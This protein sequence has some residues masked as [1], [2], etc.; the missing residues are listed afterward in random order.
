MIRISVSLRYNAALDLKKTISLLIFL[1]TCL[2][3]KTQYYSGSDIEFG[4]N[5]VQYNS[6]FWQS[7]DFERFK[8]YF[9]QSGRKH[10][11]YTAKTAHKHLQELEKFLDYETN[12]K[13]HFVVFNTQSEFRQSNI[14]LETNNITSNI[15]GTARIEGN[16]IFIYYEGDHIKLNNQI[17]T[18]LSQ[19]LVT[20]ILYGDNWKQSIKNASLLNVPE[21][22]S[23]G[24]VSYLGE[25]W[26][27]TTDNEVKNKI[28]SGRYDKFSHLTGEQ[29][30]LAGKTIWNYIDE[31]Y[32]PRMIPN[33]LYMT[34]V[35]KNI[36][37]GFIYVLGVNLSKLSDDFVN[38]YKKRYLSDI[39]GRIDPQFTQLSI[40]SRKKRVYQQ[41]KVSP[42]Q[43][44]CSFTT[45]QLG[46]YKVFLYEIEKKK[47]RKIAK[48]SHKLNRIPDYSFPNLAWHPN[49]KVLAF[50][51][52]K[53]G[54]LVLNLY[55]TETRKK[56][57]RTLLN[58]EKVLSMEYSKKG[59]KIIFSAVSS[60]QT[61]LYL[62]NILG[63]SQL[64]ITNDL[65]DDLY[66]SFT[67]ENTVIFSSN[68]PDDTLRSSGKIRTIND[69]LD[70]YLISV[71][72]EKTLKS[73]TNTPII[74]EKHPYSY[75]SKH[76][77]YISNNNGI[78]NRYIAYKDSSISYI[79]TAI[80]YNYFNVTDRLSNYPN[81][82]LELS[83]SGKNSHFSL[84]MKENDRYKFFIG[85]AEKD[86]IFEDKLRPTSF[87]EYLNLNSSENP[88]KNELTISKDIQDAEDGIVNINNYL[89]DDE[90]KETIK[91]ENSVVQDSLLN[92]NPKKE[93]KKET[94][95]LPRQDIYKV[96][97]TVDKVLMQLNPTFN[98][99]SYQRISENGFQNAGLD[100]FSIINAK[101]VF[102]DYR[103]IG[104]FKG[105]IQINNTGY[106]LIYENLKSRLDKRYL[107]SRQTYQQLYNN[108]QVKK[109]TTYDFKHNLKFPFSEVASLRL[110]NHLRFDHTVTSSTEPLTLI[111]ENENHYLGGLLLEYVYDAT[112]Q[113]GLNIQNGT[114]FK[115]WGEAY[116][117]LNVNETDFFVVGFDFRNYQ[118]IH[119]NIVFASRFALSS[120]FGSQRLLYYMGGVDNWLWAQYD[121][122][123]IPDPNQNYQFQTIATPMR[124]FFQNARNGNTFAAI[125]NEL[126][127]PLFSYFSPKPLRSDFL[128][129]F[130]VIGFND[131]GTAWT[132]VNPYSESNSFNT[133]QING[134][135]YTITLQNQKEPII[136]GYGFGL[137][138]RI[139]GYYVRFDWAW[140]VNDGVIMPSIKH[141]SLSLD[142]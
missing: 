101:D 30:R 70:I 2:L 33:I 65:Y 51:E 42:N 15:G 37:S 83:H 110:T 115:L 132:G 130:M 53:K 10:A 56:T 46:Q 60:G 39:E 40:R 34:R 24:I 97:F 9:Q 77:T 87:M 32:G 136:Y 112:R 7:Y 140:G 67:T 116:R 98:N 38:Y 99:Q 71:T 66:P 108:F 57:K 68:R 16:K 31:V 100:G 48:G 35:S 59:N 26:S 19:L 47:K 58:I 55:N 139:L 82:V 113:I 27:T 12:E 3:A 62:Y 114:K 22:F 43:K 109:T 63:N 17:R 105:P 104:G 72:G 54:N 133:T 73:L 20:R 8:I 86:L 118:K 36:E 25:P 81:D 122:S 95:A 103:I 102:E 121:G 6:F 126:R 78:Y 85:S 29:A 96:N 11:I 44:Y 14:G 49:G 90:I 137:R 124:G 5:R 89:F 18:G 142:F 129:N 128:E 21:W 64:Q 75:D 52:E 131:I 127:I 1:L 91:N 45:N 23:K 106:L 93:E 119:R 111:A 120:S 117:E 141:L 84:L 50:I 135:N 107:I 94:F 41:F 134:H 138:S 28:L 74:D 13:I 88:S 69:D 123:I 4:Q 79:D 125:N 80:H 61:D 76:Y 92:T